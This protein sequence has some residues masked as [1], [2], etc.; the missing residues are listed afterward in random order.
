MAQR[1][2]LSYV[3]PSFPPLVFASLI[4]HASLPIGSLNNP[5]HPPLAGHD[6]DRFLAMVTVSPPSSPPAYF[7][8]P[9]TMILIPTGNSSR[10]R[11][12]LFSS[13]LVVLYTSFRAFRDPTNAAQPAGMGMSTGYLPRFYLPFIGDLAE[14]WVGEE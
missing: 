4:P 13:F 6:L 9:P 7:P 5:Y 12:F 1:S 10:S 11:L 2:S 3:V 14:R 8:Y